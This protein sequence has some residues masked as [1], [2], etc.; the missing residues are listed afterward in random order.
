MF[1][2]MCGYFSMQADFGELERFAFEP[3]KEPVRNPAPPDDQP[4]DLV[5]VD[6]A[7]HVFDRNR[8][9]QSSLVKL[10]GWIRDARS[11]F[12]EEPSVVLCSDLAQH[13]D[14][15][16]DNF[17]FPTIEKGAIVE[18][19]EVVRNSARIVA[20]SQAF[21]KTE[22]LNLKSHSRVQGP[23][24]EM[25][26]WEEP[27]DVS[28]AAPSRFE[29]YAGQLT[30]A[31]TDLVNDGVP[32]H[33]CT[34]I[35]VPDDDFRQT[36]V[37][38]L[39]ELFSVRDSDGERTE[40]ALLRATDACTPITAI[41]TAGTRGPSQI[42]LD[43]MD[44]FDGMERLVVI[45][46]G[47]DTESSD[48]GDVGALSQI[49]R[50]MTRAHLIVVV[51]QHHAPGGWLEFLAA[52]EPEAPD[53]IQEHQ[54]PAIPDD[55]RITDP[56]GAKASRDRQLQPAPAPA[57]D[58]DP[59]GVPAAEEPTDLTHDTPMIDANPSPSKAE[60]A[61]ASNDGP[62]R[63]SAAATPVG[64][65][66]HDAPVLA[67]HETPKAAEA[68]GWAAEPAVNTAPPRV[69]E[70]LAALKDSP[71]RLSF[72]EAPATSPGTLDELQSP[73]AAML[74]VL[75]PAPE[76]SPEAADAVEQGPGDTRTIAEA[77]F[78]PTTGGA[79]FIANQHR[80]IVNHASEFRADSVET[81]LVVPTKIATS[82]WGRN[83][84][85][86]DHEGPIKVRA[87]FFNPYI[88][89]QRDFRKELGWLPLPSSAGVL[90]LNGS[91]EL[92]AAIQKTGAAKALSA[93]MD[94]C[95]AVGVKELM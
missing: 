49:Y 41:N 71:D 7:H 50:A 42:V 66:S 14:F 24:L 19:E 5:V 85:I 25:Y 72:V 59:D 61:A 56:E 26:I 93:L 87:N 75:E 23:P 60:D 81:E 13:G 64:P 29:R 21:C 89:Q 78:N 70:P 84:A 48:G 67:N 62:V 20:A 17:M 32:L 82:L 51:V 6:E 54:Q 34:A 57:P 79:E 58:V 63:P 16:G 68:V 74:G 83:R 15:G 22:G 28:A 95:D 31:L 76:L 11:Q 80:K 36:I 18:L 37:A 40:I 27:S 33:G 55:A 88:N 2:T 35:L 73:E 92:R 1:S 47:L 4:Y 53:A 8:S 86:V 46:V 45:A 91:T 90:E 69:A 12:I 10:N 3:Q 65:E 38:V 9:S 30:Q 39:G 77:T 94:Y 43:T 44:S 52:V